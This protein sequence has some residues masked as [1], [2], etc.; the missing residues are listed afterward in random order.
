M[1]CNNQDAVKFIANSS[2]KCTNEPKYSFHLR[3]ESDTDWLV[4]LAHLSVANGIKIVTSKTN[5]KLLNIGIVL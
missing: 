3:L 2:D 1:F 5:Q 4:F